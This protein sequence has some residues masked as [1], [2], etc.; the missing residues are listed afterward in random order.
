MIRLGSSDTKAYTITQG[1]VTKTV[2]P[3]SV[4]GSHN[5]ISWS[6][7]NWNGEFIDRPI[8]RKVKAI[9]KFDG[10]PKTG[11][12]IDSLIQWLDEKIMAGNRNFIITTWCPGL[13]WIK[14]MA[15]LGTPTN[16]SGEGIKPGSPHEMAV[17]KLELH[18]IEVGGDGKAGVGDKTIINSQ[19]L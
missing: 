16:F 19:T 6:W 12:S 8:A 14:F 9:W 4:E 1:S 15:Y 11:E 3:S 5:V 17:E 2:D 13:G 10:P 7:N 18:W